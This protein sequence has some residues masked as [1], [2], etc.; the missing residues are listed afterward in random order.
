LELSL[1][2]S[3]CKKFRVFSF[4]GCTLGFVFPG[5]HNTIFCG[6]SLHYAHCRP[7]ITYVIVNKVC[8]MDVAIVVER[9]Y[10]W[11]RNLKSMHVQ[12][13]IID[14]KILTK[15][16]FAKLENFVGKGKNLNVFH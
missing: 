14:D 7:W 4:H 11:L 10:S 6:R 2:V 16:I 12:F 9:L 13:C 5:G 15:V 1:Q 3:P 8:W